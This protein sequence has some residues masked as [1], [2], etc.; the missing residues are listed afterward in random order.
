VTS[1][2]FVPHFFDRRLS[3]AWSAASAVRGLVQV[4]LQP[5]REAGQ[6]LVE[7]GLVVSIMAIA[8][9]ATLSVI[10]VDVNDFYVSVGN[11]VADTLP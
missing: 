11:A 3:L 1:R 7:Y 5:S 8:L 10:G 2:L 9:L 4:P 6:T